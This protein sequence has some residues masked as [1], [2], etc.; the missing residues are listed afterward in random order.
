MNLSRRNIKSRKR[1]I[2]SFL[3]FLSVFLWLIF[4]LLYILFSD[5]NRIYAEQ[6]EIETYSEIKNSQKEA[7]QVK[8]DP[9]ASRIR[10]IYHEVKPAALVSPEGLREWQSFLGKDDDDSYKD[11]HLF[12]LIR[13]RGDEVTLWIQ[14]TKFKALDDKPIIKKAQS[15]KLIK[16]IIKKEETIIEKNDFEPEERE[17]VLEQILSS[18]KRKKILLGIKLV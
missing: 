7:F 12:I 6:R 2:L 18:I 5:L 4:Y 8:P 10:E 15:S 1:T 9:I 17:L 16:A 13:E 11:D 14:V 3:P